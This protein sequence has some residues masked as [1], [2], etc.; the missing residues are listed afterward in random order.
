[1]D[2]GAPSGSWSVVHVDPHDDN[3]PW[4]SSVWGATAT[5]LWIVGRGYTQVGVLHWD[6]STVA[7]SPFVDIGVPSAVWG[8]SPSNV[9]VVGESA[10]V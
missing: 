8:T 9:W 5:D 3:T 1:V 4:L 7:G 6:G 2:A 10:A